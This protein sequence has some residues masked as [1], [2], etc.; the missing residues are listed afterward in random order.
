MDMFRARR[1]TAALALAAGLFGHALAAAIVRPVVLPGAAPLAASAAGASPASAPALSAVSAQ[2]LLVAPT[3]PTAAPL[4]AFAR[5]AGIGLA[6]TPFA[7]KALMGLD[8]DHLAQY[9]SDDRRVYVNWDYVGADLRALEDAGVRA[10]EARTLTALAAVPVLAHE[11]RHAE[12]RHAFG[13]DFPG[14]AEEEFLTHLDQAAVLG[15]VLRMRP[16]FASQTPRLERLF[17]YPHSRRLLDLRALGF[18]P[19]EEHILRK[20]RGLSPSL[21]DPSRGAADARAFLASLEAAPQRAP[22]GWLERARRNLGFWEDAAQVRRLA[23]FLH[24]RIAAAGAALD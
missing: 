13:S 19:F 16:D 12:L 1:L 9:D 4:A 10:L 7:G 17:L 20:Y 15:E 2:L 21:A 8:A 23:A 6:A 18:G 3:L 24:E 11:W 22:R 5:D 14:L